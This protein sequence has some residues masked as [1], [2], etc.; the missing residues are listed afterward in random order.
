MRSEIDGCVGSQ[1]ALSEHLASL[2][3]LD[4]SAP[5]AL[6]GWTVG[7][8]LSHLARNADS[9]VA[10]LEGR[11]QYRDSAARDA[12]IEA[13]AG[14]SLDELL[15]DVRESSLALESAWREAL[16]VADVDLRWSQ[17]ALALSG[18]RPLVTL[19][20]LR[21]REVEIHR[22]DLNVGFGAVDLDRH[23]LRCDLRLCEMLWRARRPMGLTP[24]P[25]AVLATAPY[26]RLLW[27]LGRLEIDGVGWVNEVN[28][29]RA[30]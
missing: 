11:P 18:P 30:P 27:F 5:S 23:Y 25:Q 9:H 16:D 12:D 15:S 3:D 2:S 29:L 17:N 1:R 7:H 21:W 20:L 24:L 19:P 6:P 8:V 14:R 22:M 13:G 26:D 10:M 28:G 4:P